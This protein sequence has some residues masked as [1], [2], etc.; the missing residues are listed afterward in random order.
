MLLQ[1]QYL[2]LVLFLSMQ[3]ILDGGLWLRVGLQNGKRIPCNK[4][5]TACS[6]SILL[7]IYSVVVVC[8]KILID[9]KRYVGGI[10]DLF[11]RGDV[12]A[13]AG[14]GGGGV[15]TN[16]FTPMVAIPPVNMV[17]T[18]CALLEGLLVPKNCPPE[19]PKEVILLC[20]LLQ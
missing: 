5:C 7:A 8:S 13:G 12:G 6:L 16:P 10:L 20:C 1:P 14:G 9:V 18:L 4:S 11:V 19:G 3:M 17:S 15:K 2:V